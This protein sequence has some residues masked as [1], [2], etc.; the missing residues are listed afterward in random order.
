MGV[1]T[2]YLLAFDNFKIF[3]TYKNEEMSLPLI[4]IFNSEVLHFVT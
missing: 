2:S 1:F 4:C 3:A